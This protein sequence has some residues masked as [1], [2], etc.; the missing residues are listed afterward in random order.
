LINLGSGKSSFLD[1]ISQR[2]N[3]G[4]I[5]GTVYFDNKIMSKN[6]FREIGAYV[7]QDDNLLP[8]SSVHE[9]LMEAALV[10]F[11]YLTKKLR[12]GYKYSLAQKIERVKKI[13]ELLDLTQC[14]DTKIGNEWIRGIS[15]GQRKRVSI[16][17]E[18]IKDPTI[19]ACKHIF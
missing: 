10:R 13:E 5:G 15:G 14:R 11:K 8:T 19:L 16:G 18:M 3:S 9:T 17:I 7:M 2:I 6:Y 12:L 4:K 1:Y